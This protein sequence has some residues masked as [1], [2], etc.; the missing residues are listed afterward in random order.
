MLL[1]IPHSPMYVG[2]VSFP[3]SVVV[4]ALPD[5]RLAAALGVRG[6]FK[7]NL[8]VKSEGQIHHSRMKLIQVFSSYPLKIPRHASLISD[9]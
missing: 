1:F 3:L 2:F 6:H 4:F 8:G 9:M 5:T 7:R